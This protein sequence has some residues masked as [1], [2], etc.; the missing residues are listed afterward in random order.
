MVEVSFTDKCHKNVL[1]CFGLFEQ[2]KILQKKQEYQ[3]YKYVKDYKRIIRVLKIR[4]WHRTSEEPEEFLSGFFIL[5][6]LA[7]LFFRKTELLETPFHIFE[8]L[9]GVEHDEL[10]RPFGAF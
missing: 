3:T 4:N 6:S 8:H 5:K 9:R 10:N 1:L 2:G 7:L